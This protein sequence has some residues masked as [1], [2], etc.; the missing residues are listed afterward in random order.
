V[1]KFPH[2]KYDL[3]PRPKVDIDPNL[4]R[5]ISFR[6]RTATTPCPSLFACEQRK[7]PFHSSGRSWQQSCLLRSKTLGI[8]SS[9]RGS[10]R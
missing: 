2:I 1:G 3:S 9:E 4:S 10:G 7:Q 6:R 5:W 8:G